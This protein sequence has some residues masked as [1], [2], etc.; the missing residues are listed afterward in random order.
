M[1]S[2]MW[3]KT[4]TPVCS[5]KK[6]RNEVAKLVAEADKVVVGAGAGLS[7]AAGL[8]Y[9]GPRFE[10]EFAD[11]IER[12]GFT[13]LYSSSFYPFETEEEF[14]AC[15]ARHIDFVSYQTP[16]LPLYKEL[17]RSLEGKDYSSLRPTWTGN[18]A[19][20]ASTNSAFLPP[21]ATTGFCNVAKVATTSC[22]TTRPW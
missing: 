15:W 8:R 12:Y 5:P 17:L 13:D 22:T 18:F 19:S 21:K 10:R 9:D 6:A 4:F 11:F 1:Y 20:P 2:K 16:A 14:W 7:I 3:T